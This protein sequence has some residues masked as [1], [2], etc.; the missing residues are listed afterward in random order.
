MTIEEMREY[1]KKHTSGV[2]LATMECSEGGGRIATFEKFV[3]MVQNGYNIVKADVI[4]YD[5][6][7][8][9][10]QKRMTDEKKMGGR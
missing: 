2:R 6:I 4:N 3:E 5:M 8:V 7:D 10:F 9:E 1:A